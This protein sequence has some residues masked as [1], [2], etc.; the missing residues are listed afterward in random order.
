MKKSQEEMVGFVLIVIIIIIVGVIFLGLALRKGSSSYDSSE[1]ENFLEASAITTTDCAINYIP[2]YENLQG[3]I[4][5]CYDNQICLNGNEACKELNL[6]LSRLMDNAWV[7]DKGSGYLG[8]E[9]NVNYYLNNSEAE[10]PII[11]LEKGNCSSG[12]GGEKLIAK[13]PGNIIIRLEV[14]S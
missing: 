9:L 5:S 7:I 3:L 6:S 13:Y 2:N 10:H 12:T 11:K 8:W 1:I 4:G 14:C